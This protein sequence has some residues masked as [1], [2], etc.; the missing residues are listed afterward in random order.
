MQCNIAGFP[1][2]TVP[3]TTNVVDGA[4]VPFSLVFAGL[5]NSEASLLALVHDYEQATLL[6][7]VPELA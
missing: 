2:V 6:R 3:S 1:V 7:V 5:P 4:P